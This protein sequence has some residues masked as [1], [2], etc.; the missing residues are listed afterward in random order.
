MSNNTIISKIH[1]HDNKPSVL[2]LEPFYGGS[3]KQLVDYLKQVLI[4][5]GSCD[6]HMLTMSDK[7][8]HWR[9]RTSALYF[10][11]QISQLH[12]INNRHIT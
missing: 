12:P 10:S 2:L 1:H 5:D 11:Q 4:R 9:M 6:V 3:H 8:W 7:K